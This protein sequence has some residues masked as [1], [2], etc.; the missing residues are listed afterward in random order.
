MMLQEDIFTS[1]IKCQ[2]LANEKAT[3][4]EELEELYIKWE[5]LAE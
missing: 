3:I 1:S 2:E 5:E 4:A